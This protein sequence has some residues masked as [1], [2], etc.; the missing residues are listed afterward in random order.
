M[1]ERESR[2]HFKT[3]DNFEDPNSLKNNTQKKEVAE[4]L[5]TAVR[6]RGTQKSFSKDVT[7]FY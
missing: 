6:K 4:N 2:I 7:N 1:D 3:T 5:K